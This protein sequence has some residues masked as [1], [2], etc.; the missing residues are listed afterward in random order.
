[1]AFGIRAGGLL[2]GLPPEDAAARLSGL[3]LGTEI[4][5]ARRRYPSTEV[6]L[7]ASGGLR[8]LYEKA[9]EIAGVTA[10]TV[11]AD[12]AVRAG[13]VTAAR[14]NGMLEMKP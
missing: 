10:K 14:V 11:D 7:V 6:V 13:L 2:H 3:M 9:F 4:A 8:T 12:E 1:L 5:S